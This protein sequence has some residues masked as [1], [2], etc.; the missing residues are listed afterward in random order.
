MFKKRKDKDREGP[1]AGDEDSSDP[2]FSRDPFDEFSKAFGSFRGMDEMMNDLMR[3][4]FSSGARIE[5]GRPFVYGF[6]MKSG[7]D[8]KPMIQEFGNV[9]PGAKNPVISD[10]REPMVDIVE[11]DKDIIVIAELPGVNKG[12]I[13]LGATANSLEIKSRRRRRSTTRRCSCRLQSSK[14]RRTLHI[15]M[16]S[17]RSS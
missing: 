7:P 5:K 13:D 9:K 11:R 3:N 1:D 6:S 2:I 8:G 15:I 4:L 10:A 17:W 12:D 16:A 14:T